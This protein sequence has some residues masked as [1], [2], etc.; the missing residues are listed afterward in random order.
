MGRPLAFALL[1]ALAVPAFAKDKQIDPVEAQFDV[2]YASADAGGRSKA[3]DDLRAAPDPLKFWLVSN[4]VVGRE[5]RADVVAHAV[6]VLAS[7]KDEKVVGSMVVAAKN[8]PT[9]QRAVY[10]E[11]MAS[12]AGS[13]AAH[14]ALLELV[15]DRDTYIRGMA[16]AALGEHRSM[17]ALPS[18]MALLDD[19]AWM[20]QCAALSA[21]PRLSDKTALKA[22]LGKLVELMENTSGRVRVDCSEA[23]RRITGKNLGVE[24]APWRKAYDAGMLVGEKPPE[25]SDADKPEQFKPAYANQEEKPHYYGMPVLSNRVVLVLDISLSMYDA[26][27]IDKDRLRRETSR[28]KPV[29][30]GE[31][32]SDDPAPAEDQGYDIPWW[33]VKT[34]LD[35][36]KYQMMN[37]VS[38]LR[39]EQHFEIILFSKEVTHWMSKLVPATSINK[40]KAMALLETIKPED[41]TN[42]WGAIAAAFDMV[43]VNK[44]GDAFGPDEMYFVT[45]GAPS[46]GDITDMEQILQATLQLCKV[47][48]LKINII[49]IG[50]DLNFL[51]KLARDTGGQSKFFK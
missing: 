19:K 50:V 16:A 3:I 44:K 8:G 14:T 30:T 21:L 34:R 1:A 9:E 5:K 37:L 7:I 10:V 45:D 26:I 43:D 46:V 38:M 39:D 27:E 35:L 4:R 40:Q 42:T 22:Q 15:K 23:M 36:A 28:R 33:K 13:T 49:G 17:D 6:D 18:L 25:E 32:K 41:A 12:L 29:V 24:P 31:K 20:V 47:K 48:P 2:H 11:A 51:R